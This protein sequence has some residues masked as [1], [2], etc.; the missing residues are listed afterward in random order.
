[1]ESQQRSAVQSNSSE[2]V[3]RPETLRKSTEAAGFVEGATP[4]CRGPRQVLCYQ[5]AQDVLLSRHAA[6][7]GAD[8]GEVV[9]LKVS[10]DGDGH[11]FGSHENYEVTIGTGI[12]LWTWRLILIPAMF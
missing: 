10:H 7:S 2:Q 5:R 8:D 12:A 6:A 9:L 4:E 1:M 3:A 11:H